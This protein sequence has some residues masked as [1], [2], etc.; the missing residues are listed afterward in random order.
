MCL[1]KY[2][3]PVFIYYITIEIFHTHTTRDCTDVFFHTEATVIQCG[4]K[5]QINNIETQ[6]H[7]AENISHKSSYDIARCKDFELV[8]LESEKET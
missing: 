2:A 5:K 4:L 1:S 7:T 6:R 8:R 3:F